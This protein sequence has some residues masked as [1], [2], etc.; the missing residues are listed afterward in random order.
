MEGI[1]GNVMHF[2]ADQT[3]FL[4]RSAS[5]WHDRASEPVEHND[6]DR[7]R[8]DERKY[9]LHCQWLFCSAIDQRALNVN[10][11]C[12]LS[13]V[14]KIRG[15]IL[16]NCRRRNHKVKLIAKQMSYFPQILDGDHAQKTTM[17]LGGIRFQR[18]W[19]S[20]HYD[21]IRWSTWWLCIGPYYT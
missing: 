13:V 18:C 10:K 4:L 14:P 11:K 16:T 3:H 5:S 15:S 8:K 9:K 1:A 2:P 17:Q 6:E 20:K 7:Y 21:M 12:W 19:D